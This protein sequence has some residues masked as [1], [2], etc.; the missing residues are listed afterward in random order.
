MTYVT[1]PQTIQVQDASG[2]SFTIQAGTQYD[3]Q[4]WTPVM[5]TTNLSPN[6]AKNSA[7]ANT[8]GEKLDMLGYALKTGI[9]KEQYDQLNETQ[10]AII[11]MVGEQAGQVYSTQGQI[12]FDEAINNAMK[13]PAVMAKYSDAVGLDTAAF[14]QS[15]QQIQQNASTTAKA[16]AIQFEQDKKSILD[17]YNAAGVSSS[18]YKGKALAQL[19]EQEAGIVQSSRS[20]TQNELNKLAA[21]FEAK[22]GT[23]ALPKTSIQTPANISGTGVPAASETMTGQVTGGI[24]GSQPISKSADVL[25]QAYTN[26]TDHNFQPTVKTIQ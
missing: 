20:K 8:G 15:L 5:N 6:A 24:T 1:A 12:T 10:R 21:D 14:Q 17:K 11:S 2:R 3:D 16:Q 7:K 22:Y 4:A 9:T 23:A 18:G 13:D 26:V 25:S 19:K